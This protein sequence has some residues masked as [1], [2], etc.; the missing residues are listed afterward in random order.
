MHLPPDLS[1]VHFVGIGGI[2]MSAVAKILQAAG[3]RVSGSDLAEN[4][5]VRALRDLGIAVAIGEDAAN[6]PAD[7]QLL[8]HTSA[9]PESNRERAAAKA[10]GIPEMTNFAFL[11]EWFRHR[12]VVLVCGTHG[13]STTTAMLGLMLV[14]AGLD[15]TVLVGS[16]VP[17][18]ADGNLRLGEGELVVI[19]GDEYARH[20]LEFHPQAVALLNIELDHTDIFPTLD[21]MLD[22]FRELLLRISKKGVLVANVGDLNVRALLGQ[23][24]VA[25]L[26]RDLSV[27]HVNGEAAAS[28][29]VRYDAEKGE[30][31]LSRDG[32]EV[33]LPLH[34]PGRI[35]ALNAAMAAA[36]A[37][38]LGAD[39]DAC[40][41]ALGA[42]HGI[43]RRFEKIAERDGAVFY[44]DYAHHP[45]AVR[46]TL[47]AAHEAFPDRRIVACVQPHH[48]KRTRDLFFEF[49]AAFDRADV[50]VLAEIYEPSGRT[51]EETDR[52]SSED[53][54]EVLARRDAEAA[55]ER[56]VAYAPDAKAAVA[57]T[58]AEVRPGDIVLFM[59][60]G[61]LD[62][63]ARKALGV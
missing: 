14:E 34:V 52:I 18:F 17:A 35:N 15:P 21:A 29:A 60:A 47:K 28:W 45:T 58:L 39:A 30:A 49:E 32:R 41:R 59:A 11:G 9:A 37:M 7:A 55:R 51:V 23:E 44:S 12:K 24:S 61:D 50:L 26:E 53:F 56:L 27:V 40:V 54:L 3:V 22:A 46:E 42:F 19:E 31:L 2:S 6:I 10:R 36:L 16:R 33:R 63:A 8:I 48:R 62:V 38:A 57:R 25:L 13:K 5:Q 20:F 1:A 43:W 4:E